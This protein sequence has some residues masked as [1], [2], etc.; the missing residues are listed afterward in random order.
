[1]DNERIWDVIFTESQIA[2]TM[3]EGE[4]VVYRRKRIM[5]SWN[6]GSDPAWLA[7]YD[8]NSRIAHR[9]YI[10]IAGQRP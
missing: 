1:M 9:Y 5:A 6:E 3:T 8:G 4:W 2:V 10:R 7:G